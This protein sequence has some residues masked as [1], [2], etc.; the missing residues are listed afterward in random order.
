MFYDDYFKLDVEQAT[1]FKISYLKSLVNENRIY[2]F[3]SFDDNMQLN[4]FKI[5][6]LINDE[7]WFSHFRKLNDPS[8]FEISYSVKKIKNKLGKSKDYIDHFIKTIIEIYDVCSFSY[9]YDGYMWSNY[10][11]EGNGICLV[12]E[13]E[14]FDMLYPVEYKMKSKINFDK[15]VIDS[16]KMYE[17]LTKRKDRAFFND[18]MS[19]YPWVVKNPRNGIYDS[20]KEKEVRILYSPYEFGEFNNGIIDEGVKKNLQY[21]GLNVKYSDVKLKLDML[22]IGNNCSSEIVERIK[23]ICKDKKVECKF[24]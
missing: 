1:K 2:K 7:I 14:D 6:S 8:E 16:F 21:Q 9:M 22:V 18:P 20:T 4:H 17:R 12:F 19:L 13:V 23:D 15:M 10:A 3:I 24:L 11:N 5:Q